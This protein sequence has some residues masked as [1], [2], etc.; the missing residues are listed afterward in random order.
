MRTVHITEVL[1]YLEYEMAKSMN[2]VTVRNKAVFLVLHS[3]IEF[4]H[5]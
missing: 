4:R 2:N 3:D 1:V 5:L